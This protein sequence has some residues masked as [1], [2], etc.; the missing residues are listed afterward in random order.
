MQRKAQSWSVD[1]MLGVILFMG[2]IFLFY[3]IL[4]SDENANAA[5]LK[6]DAST[7][8]K[9]VSSDKS[10]GIIDD[11]QINISKAGQLKNI[12]YEEL[13]QR[14][15][16]GGDFCIYMEDENGNIVLINDSYRGIGAPSINISGA[17]CSQK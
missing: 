5:N 8:I 12:S 10:L 16:V 6:D 4:N 14:L 11:N 3:A 7:V 9:A 1:I 15:R 13:K 17:P 2:A